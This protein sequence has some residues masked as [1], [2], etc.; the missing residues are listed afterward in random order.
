[1]AERY[2][3]FPA[4]G[5]AILLACGFRYLGR[6]YAPRYAVILTLIALTLLTP[7]TWNRNSEWS[8]ELRLFESEYRNGDQSTQAARLLT[9]AYI[10]AGNAGRAAEICD[11]KS[12]ENKRGGRYANHCAIAYSLLGRNEDAERAF[13]AA[14][15]RTSADPVIIS[16]LAQFYLRQGRREDAARQFE[17]AIEREHDPALQAYRRGEM[18]VFLYPRDRQ[19]LLEALNQFREAVRLKPRLAVAQ[20]R[21]DQLDRELNRARIPYRGASVIPARGVMV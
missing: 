13:L 16:N 9:A 8:S 14:T 6:R 12:F 19:K 11:A 18:L 7:L 2:L 1:M 15:R 20:A 5:L 17:R 4:S 3:Y 21:L 10:E